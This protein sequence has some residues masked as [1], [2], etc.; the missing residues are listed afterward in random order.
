MGKIEYK[1]ILGYD[2]RNI[3]EHPRAKL[4]GIHFARSVNKI[5]RLVYEDYIAAS[6]TAVLEETAKIHTW[7]K[8][9][10]AVADYN[11]GKKRGVKRQLVGANRISASYGFY[12]FSCKH[13]AAL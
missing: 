3:L 13:I 4:R 10:V 12:T 7:V 9:I 11:V 8:Q 1:I 6:V 2:R 5:V